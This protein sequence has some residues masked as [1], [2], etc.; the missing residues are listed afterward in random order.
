M[1]ISQMSTEKAFE[2]MVR[3]VP[4]VVEIMS[5]PAVAEAKAKLKEKDGELTGGDFMLAMYP[6]LM[7]DHAEALC[8]IVAA[9][10]EKTP[11]EVKA[12]P[13]GETLA[14]LGAGITKELFDFFPFAVR[15]VASM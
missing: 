15:L 11:D 4:Y 2:C 6:L 8:G 1:N 10:S 5:D 3:M 13:L 9:M 7:R 12:Q 14:A